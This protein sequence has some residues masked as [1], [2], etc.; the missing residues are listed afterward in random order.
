[1]TGITLTLSS[2]SAGAVDA[3]IQMAQAVGVLVSFD[4]NYRAA[5]WSEE[6]AG[7][8]Y[9]TILPKVDVVFAGDEEAALG[10][11]PSED[12]MEL[13]RRIAAMGSAAGH[14]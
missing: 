1:M 8:A 3:A 5:L 2:E 12:S 9:R 7:Q 4:L 6:E 13:A 14:H 11:G 10:V